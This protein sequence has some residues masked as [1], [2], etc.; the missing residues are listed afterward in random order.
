MELRR[1]TRLSKTCHI[2][3]FEYLQWWSCSWKVLFSRCGKCKCIFK[4]KL[5]KSHIP[6]GSMPGMV[7]ISIHIIYQFLVNFKIWYHIY[8]YISISGDHHSIIYYSYIIDPFKYVCPKCLSIK[9][10]VAWVAI[11]HV[12]KKS[13][14]FWGWFAST[15]LGVGCPAVHDMPWLGPLK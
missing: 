15:W 12:P 1:F 3:M 2:T 11:C 10:W 5:S 8:I 9:L 7:N 6:I 13:P 14:G 4:N